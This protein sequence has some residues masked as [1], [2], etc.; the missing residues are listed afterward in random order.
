MVMLKIKK[1]I[2]PIVI[3]VLALG[4]VTVLAGCS[5]TK[6]HEEVAQQ[7]ADQAGLTA[8]GQSHFDGT[9]IAPGSNFS[10]YKKLLVERLDLEK[11]EI[12]QP[13]KTGMSSAPWALTEEDKRFYQER[14]TEA[15]INNLIAD[16][17]YAT[18][19]DPAA[20]VLTIKARVVQIAP[21]AVKDD[22]NSRQ[23]IMKV[24]T[25][26][27]GSVTLEVALHDSITGK[28]LGI[29][30]DKRDLGRI[31]EENNRVTNNQQV[32]LAFN[33]WLRKLRSELEAIS[34]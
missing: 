32:R 23:G 27:S 21:A 25:E 30:T 15:L 33:S 13:P 29:I 1:A 11:V 24:Y 18:A 26:G 8:V 6:K 2:N 19:V 5:Q 7:K 20:D 16:G 34:K 3:W 10:Q 9:F 22:I 28:L 17:A 12:I 14:Y 4:I 31:W